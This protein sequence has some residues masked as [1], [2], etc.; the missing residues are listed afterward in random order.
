MLEKKQ[1]AYHYDGK[2]KEDETEI[3]IVGDMAVPEK[4]QM[5]LR[6]DG[7]HWKVEMTMTRHD[8]GGALPV[9]LVYLASV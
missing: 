2:I 8:G 6:P 3:D 1:V 4:G 9:H 5:I 7:K